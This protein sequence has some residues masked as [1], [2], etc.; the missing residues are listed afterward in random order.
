MRTIR[1]SRKGSINAISIARREVVDHRDFQHFFVIEPV[2]PEVVFAVTIAVIAADDE[3]SAGMLEQFDQRAEF[4]I[5]IF[6]TFSLAFLAEFAAVVVTKR[7]ARVLSGGPVGSS[8]VVRYM[9]FAD[10]DEDEHRLVSVFLDF[11]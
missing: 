9:R 2:R 7:H 1:E 3:R 5:D 6:E 10:I 8:I 11:R 4:E